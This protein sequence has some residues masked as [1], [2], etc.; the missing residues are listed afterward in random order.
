MSQPAIGL[1]YLRR[2]R[3]RGEEPSYPVI[4]STVGE[5][6]DNLHVHLNVDASPSLVDWSPM[7]GLEAFAV[8]GAGQLKRFMQHA[9]RLL[10]YGIN[11]FP[12]WKDFIHVWDIDRKNGVHVVRWPAWRS[13]Y[14][15]L[16]RPEQIDVLPLFHWEKQQLADMGLERA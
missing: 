10:R 8:V 5:V 12:G 2:L 9:A 13:P 15:E 7:H 16:A 14:P 4:V 1:D 3:A 11:Q 6:A